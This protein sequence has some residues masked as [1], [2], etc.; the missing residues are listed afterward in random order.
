M[1]INTEG[2]KKDLT[3]PHKKQINI[4]QLKLYKMSYL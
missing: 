4:Q 3:R 2:E 1:N